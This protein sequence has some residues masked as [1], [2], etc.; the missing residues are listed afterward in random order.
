MEIGED[1]RKSW[2]RRR[3]LRIGHDCPSDF[4]VWQQGRNRL[5]QEPFYNL[6]GIKGLYE[7]NRISFKEDDGSGNLYTVHAT[8]RQ[9]GSIESSLKDYAKLL[10]RRIGPQSEFL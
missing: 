3:S 1:A 6:F 10:K 7:G 4:R 2:T 5:S 8:F 9:Y